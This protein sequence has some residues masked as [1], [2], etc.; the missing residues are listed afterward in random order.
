MNN[1][2]RDP[3]ESTEQDDRADDRPAAEQTEQSDIP[4]ARLL[5]SVRSRAAAW[6]TAGTRAIRGV[7]VV[8]W[9]SVM[10]CSLVAI[11]ACGIAY[12]SGAPDP[13]AD[14][15]GWVSAIYDAVTS[16]GVGHPPGLALVPLVHVARRLGPDVIRGRVGGI[17]LNVFIAIAATV[18]PVLAVGGHVDA[19]LI[20]SAL[21]AALAAS[22]IWEILKDSVPAVNAAAAKARSTPDSG[23]VVITRDAE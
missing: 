23:D 5:S 6:L 4:R 13:S 8:A 2:P 10:F 20:V 19:G 14:P 11:G 15:S 7:A 1:A 18:S 12:A 17:L 9:V 3:N 21:T 22:G 16:R